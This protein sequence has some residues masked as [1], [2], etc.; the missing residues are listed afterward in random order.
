MSTDAAS[1]VNGQFA[2]T[3]DLT[4]SQRVQEVEAIVGRIKTAA[5]PDELPRLATRA[6]ELLSSCERMLDDITAQTDA[7]LSAP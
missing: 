5:A 6:R 2:E 1:M 3:D 7:A 4:Y